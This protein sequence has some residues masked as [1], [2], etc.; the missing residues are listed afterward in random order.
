[1]RGRFGL[2][3]RLL[4][5][6]GLGLGRELGLLADFELPSSTTADAN[7]SH[8]YENAAKESVDENRLDHNLTNSDW[9]LLSGFGSAGISKG[10]G[11]LAGYG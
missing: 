7:W 4:G 8:W 2:T 10:V 6:L 9:L 11:S 5:R 3:G 1:M